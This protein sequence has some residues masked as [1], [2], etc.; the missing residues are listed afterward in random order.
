MTKILKPFEDAT[1]MLKKIFRIDAITCD[2]SSEFLSVLKSNIF[3]GI[4]LSHFETDE[5][6]QLASILDLLFKLL[7]AAPEKSEQLVSLLPKNVSSCD[8]S[9]S[10]GEDSDTSHP[11]KK[12]KYDISKL[13]CV[14]L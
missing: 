5:T 3:G 10:D 9:I 8:A 11:N 4:F 7:W 1:L 12:H 13:R 14:H 2:Y 6:Y